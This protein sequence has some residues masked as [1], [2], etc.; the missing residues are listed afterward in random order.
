MSKRKDNDEFKGNEPSIRK[1][2]ER[3]LIS[4]KRKKREH[5][6]NHISVCNEKRK[7]AKRNTS[8]VRYEHNRVIIVGLHPKVLGII[9][10]NKM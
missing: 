8:N 6:I 4:R 10:E 2:I 1:K 9:P 5:E 7:V 3:E